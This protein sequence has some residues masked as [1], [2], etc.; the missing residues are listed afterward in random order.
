MLTLVLGAFAP[1]TCSASQ[2]GGKFAQGCDAAHRVALSVKATD[3]GNA[4]ASK[5]NMQADNMRSADIATDY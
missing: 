2:A 1:G 3:N 5:Q 4:A